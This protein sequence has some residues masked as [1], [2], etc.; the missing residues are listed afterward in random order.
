[1]LGL[2]TIAALTLLYAMLAGRAT[3]EAILVDS[4][5]DLFFLFRFHFNVFSMS[6]INIPNMNTMTLIINTSSIIF[7][8][9]SLIGYSLPS[10]AVMVSSLSL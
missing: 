3:H 6:R 8:S 9:L 7:Y 2:A 10:G 5:S 4:R 1:M